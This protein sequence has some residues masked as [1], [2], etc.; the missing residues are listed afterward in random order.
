MSGES[1]GPS[2]SKA[3]RRLVELAPSAILCTWNSRRVYPADPAFEQ[4][5]AEHGVRVPIEVRE[6]GPG[7]ARFELVHGERRRRA[8]IKAAL[9]TVEALVVSCDKLSAQLRNVG[10]NVQ[11]KNLHAW[12][13]AEA[14]TEIADQHRLSAEQIAARL[15]MGPDYVRNLQRVKRRLNKQIW[16]QLRELG[17]DCAVGW[18]QLSEIC[19]L[20]PESEQLQEWSRRLDKSKGI[21]R[22][23]PERRPGPLKLGK[24]LQQLSA[25]PRS[26]EFRRG[27]TL[28]FKVALGQERWPYQTRRDKTG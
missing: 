19:M 27:A 3:P 25:V 18:T 15:K 20:D 7:P 1:K 22:R 2:L 9:P 4:D 12:E 6:I 21:V 17:D 11:R 16:S 28:A 13:L 24:F 10:E 14:L 23:G 26:L 8:A 5:I